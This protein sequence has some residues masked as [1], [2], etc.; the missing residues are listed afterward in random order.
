MM[1]NNMVEAIKFTYIV[2]A[3]QIESCRLGDNVFREWD[4]LDNCDPFTIQMVPLELTEII[5]QHNVQEHCA[6]PTCCS[7]Y[8]DFQLPRR[9]ASKVF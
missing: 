1:T 3:E 2:G 8:V 4:A 6:I 7:R 5:H 9:I